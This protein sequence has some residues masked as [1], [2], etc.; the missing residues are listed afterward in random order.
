MV[1]STNASTDFPFPTGRVF[2]SLPAQSRGLPQSNKRIPK[3]AD[4]SEEISIGTASL[5]QNA[6][7]SRNFSDSGK[8]ENFLK[9]G[10]GHLENAA[11]PA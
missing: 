3:S 9:G 1:S 8:S 11:T 2:S 6:G 7:D 5:G 4:Y 10:K